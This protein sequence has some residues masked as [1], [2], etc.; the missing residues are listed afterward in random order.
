LLYVR[1]T[2]QLI[3]EQG[4]AEAHQQRNAVTEKQVD[5]KLR[6]RYNEFDSER[7][8]LLILSTAAV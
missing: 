1:L 4:S 5:E 7:K 3:R 6:I 8:W 2:H